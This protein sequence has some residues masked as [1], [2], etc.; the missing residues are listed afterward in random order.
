VVVQ[1][2]RQIEAEELE[3]IRQTVQTFWRLSLC[4]L[5]QTVCE[6][7][8]WHTVSGSNKVDACI[9]LLRRLE[10]QGL[11]RLP[12]KRVQSKTSWQ[13]VLTE[14]TE[15]PGEIV[16]K[17]SDIR[18]VRL[19]VVK[20]GEETGLFN[21]YVSRYHY[22]GYKKPFG[23]HLRYFI[24]G[25]GAI[26]GCTLFSGA[27]K[28]LRVRDGWI[29]WNESERLIN[30]GFVVNNGRF[31]IFP[32]VKVRYLAS[33]VL[34]KIVRCL[35]QDW[36]QRWG[37]RPVLLETFVDPQYF[38]GTSYLAAGFDYLGMTSGAGLVREGKSYKTSPKKIF[39]RPLVDNFR[40]VLCSRQ[41]VGGVSK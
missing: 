10:V 40:D 14:R 6:H 19:R 27:A 4:E 17:L 15:P 5:A 16:G 23:Y 7:L 37:Y 18:P 12:A 39:V 41:T 11:I 24:E 26:L 33:H 36:Q 9:K 30:L 8:R 22:L 35:S 28:A 20:D 25:A 31:I 3:Q 2:G 34:G 29:G 1:C 38:N 13:P 21:E 32:W